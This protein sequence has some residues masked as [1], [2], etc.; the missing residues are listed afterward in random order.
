MLDLLFFERNLLDRGEVVVGLDE[1]GRGA[2]AGPMTVGAVVVTTDT[3]PPAGLND[4]KLLSASKRNALVEPLKAWAAD[5]SLGSVTSSEV[6][7]WGIRLALAV[8]A[9]R[10]IEGLRI[11]PSHALIDG[12]FNLLMAPLDVGF[13]VAS[14]PELKYSRL[15]AI[16]IVKGDQKC[17]SIA[18]AAVLAKVNRDQ[19]MVGLH[20]SNPEFGWASNKGYGAPD[21]LEALRLKGPSPFHRTSWKLPDRASSASRQ[22]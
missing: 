15:R 14:P 10:A 4:S 22:T 21:H 5:W 7:Q 12:S 11:A 8:A 1:V 13:G 18:A 16:M 2:L 3:V 17:A 19:F 9:T 6:D 20:E